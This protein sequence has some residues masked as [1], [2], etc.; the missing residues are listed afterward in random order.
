MTWQ[1]SVMEM[2]IDDDGV[3]M[4]PD[5]ATRTGA[6]GLMQMK[7]RMQAA[8]GEMR[9]EPGRAGGTSVV[10]RIPAEVRTGEAD[11]LAG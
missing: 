6:H 2:R 8:G 7:F 4:P 9:T 3:G 5:A 11:R 10:L 1:H